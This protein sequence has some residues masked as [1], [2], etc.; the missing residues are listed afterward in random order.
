MLTDENNYEIEISE[1][2]GFH[3]SENTKNM[4]EELFAVID[5]NTDKNSVIYGFPTLKYLMCFWIIVI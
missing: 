2:E 3:V 5:S 1:L 4:Y